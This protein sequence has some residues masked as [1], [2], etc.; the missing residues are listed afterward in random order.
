MESKEFIIEF[1]ADT[2]FEELTKIIESVGG[3]I[4]HKLENRLAILELNQSRTKTELQNRLSAKV[5]SFKDDL[6]DLL[7]GFNTN[8]ILFINSIK[9]R[10]SERFRGLR[11]TR[12]MAGT[13]WGKSGLVAPDDENSE[14]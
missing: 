9:N 6:E 12:P 5:Y 3:K 1:Q 7:S 10:R 11:A 14:N 8:E 4:K 13:R 2:D